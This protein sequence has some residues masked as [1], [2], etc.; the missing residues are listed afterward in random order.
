MNNLSQCR[1]VQ[2]LHDL[3]GRG[4]LI[5]GG[6][7]GLGLQIAHALGEAGATLLV[8]ARRGNELDEA[9]ELLRAAGHRAH[10]IVADSSDETQLLNLAE[11]AGEAL[12]S[13]DILVNNAGATWGAPAAD[14]PTAA[15]DKVMNV[16]AR[17]LFILTRE[18]G[19]RYMIPRRAGRVINVASVAALGG[20]L[21]SMQAIAYHSS[22]GAVTTFTRTLA[23][24]WG[25]HGINVNAVLPGFFPTRMARHLTDSPEE[26]AR[27]SSRI[28]LRRIGDDEA[29]K[30]A[31]LLFASDAGKHITGQILAVDG[32]LTSVLSSS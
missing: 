29:L 23:C 15:W 32:G 24:E 30:G 31:V 1:T 19:R 25:P 20:A 27:L 14:H 10:A 16:N 3:S 11:R 18:I 12:G 7:R 9:V 22:K 2:Q 13:V 6:S 5:T 21:D 17:G 28:P 8:S 4:A 26:V